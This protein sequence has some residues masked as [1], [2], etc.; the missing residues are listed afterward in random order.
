V[1]VVAFLGVFLIPLFSSSLRG[2]THVLTCQ[3][4][5][6][7]PFTL[8]VPEDGPPQVLSSITLE[9]GVDATLCGGLTLDLRASGAGPGNIKMTV[10][11]NNATENVWQGSV[12]LALEGERRVTFPVTIGE[13][14]PGED[15]SDTITISLP[16]G[17]HELG[18]SL[19][20]GP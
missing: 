19:L 4:E 5:V 7:T 17:N 9:R 18:G 13:L 10:V 15:S 1:A 8:I 14:G 2:L 6:A 3:D 20:I 11:I 16:K 12:S